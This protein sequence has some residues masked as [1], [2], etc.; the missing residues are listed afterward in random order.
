MAFLI[1]EPETSGTPAG[2]DADGGLYVL[3]TWLGDDVVRAYPAVLATTPV[4]EALEDLSRSTGF[5]MRRARVKQSKFFR[6]H[7]PEKDLPEFWSV[8]VNGQ[9]GRDDIG[10]TP[11]GG[12]VISQRVLEALL[13]FRLT[14]AV[15]GQYRAGK[16][17]CRPTSACS[18]RAARW[19]PWRAARS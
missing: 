7:S 14:Q 4:K 15:F 16:S 10:L 13:N 17:E 2:G 3:D 5:C 11:E 19:W 9:P 8:V 12:L 18:R 6:Q 1:L